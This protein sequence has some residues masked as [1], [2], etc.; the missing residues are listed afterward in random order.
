[1]FNIKEKRDYINILFYLITTLCFLLSLYNIIYQKK[2]EKENRINLCKVQCI[3]S[4]SGFFY[5]NTNLSGSS[6]QEITDYYKFLQDSLYACINCC[7]IVVSEGTDS[8]CHIYNY[9]SY[10]GY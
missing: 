3:S 6:E 5:S 8:A 4:A 7:Y 9:K 10:N 1:M 2:Y